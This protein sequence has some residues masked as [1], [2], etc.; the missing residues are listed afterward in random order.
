MTMPRLL[1]FIVAFVLAPAAVAH[2]RTSIVT[3]PLAGEQT[4]Q[5]LADLGFDVTHD[6]TPERAAVI[7]HGDADRRRL[8]AAGFAAEEVVADLEAHHRRARALDAQRAATGPRS[9]LPS[10]RENYRVLDEYYDELDDLAVANPGLVRRVDLP[11]D[12]VEGRALAGVELASNVNRDDDGRPVYVVMGVHHAREWPSAEVSMEFALD[13]ADGYGTDPRITALLDRVRVVVFPVINPDGFVDSRGTVPGPPDVPGPDPL[14][15]KNANEVDLNRN[16]GAYWGGNGASTDPADDTYRGPSPW[17]EPESRAVHEF[18]QKL[19]ITNFQSIHN[20]ASLVLRPPGFEALG[21]APDEERLKLLGDAM[22]E[23]TGYASEYGYQLYEV[24]GATEDWNYVAQNAFGYTIELGGST[25]PGDFQGTYQT[26]VIQQY[27]GADGQRDNGDGVREAL[28]LA[29]EQAGDVRDHT[30]LQGTTQPGAIL[31]LRKSFQTATS[32][33]CA[34]P[35]GGGSSDCPTTGPAQLLADGLDT[36]LT[37]P[38]SGRFEWHVNPSTRPFE[39]K[40]GRTEAWTLSCETPGGTVLSV[41]DLVAG[42]GEGFEGDPCT[43]GS[44]ITRF[45]PATAEPGGT[46]AAAA[47]APGATA[48]AAGT[49]AA[50]RLSLSLRHLSR[51]QRATVLRR[52]VLV[53]A[54][55]ALDCTLAA[56]VRRSGA[57]RRAR[58]AARL[59]TVFGRRTLRLRAGRRV[60]FRVRLSAT[61]RRYLRRRPSVKR[62]VLRLDA[63]SGAQRRVSSRGIT[64]VTR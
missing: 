39:R 34:P 64:L 62:V 21:L 59:G 1:T 49:P 10:T 46:S 58:A 56:S 3:V 9:N 4:A 42:I 50:R 41:R 16:Y 5:R 53:R 24:T 27:L 31:R 43:P 15:R 33:I 61:A 57:G 35:Y 36:R 47:A 25:I 23:A 14:Q 30:V 45:R 51:Q 26:H 37:V 20:I 52:G 12:S 17:S 40:L 48:G 19:H 13:L 18:S 28:L 63:R 32:A 11:D 6:V 54:T 38:A 8:A 29:G 22:A 7:L 60:T 44:A 55:C 2:A